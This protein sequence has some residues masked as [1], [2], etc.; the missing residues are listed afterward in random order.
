LELGPEKRKLFVEQL[1]KDVAVSFNLMYL[2]MR[3]CIK[4]TLTFF[5]ICPYFIYLF[6]FKLLQRLNIMDYSLLVGLHDTSRGNKDKVREDFFVFQ[7]CQELLNIFEYFI[8]DNIIINTF[9]I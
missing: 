7:V 6:I 9:F 5:N 3:M 1:E 2:L 8:F 4:F